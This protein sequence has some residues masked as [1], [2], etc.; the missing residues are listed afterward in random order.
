MFRVRRI[1]KPNNRADT[2][3]LAGLLKRICAAYEAKGR[4]PAT[5]YMSGFATP[6]DEITVCAEWDQESIESNPRAKV[7][8]IIINKYAGE[9]SALARSNEVEFHE[10]ATDEK[11]RQWGE[12]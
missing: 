10:I 5:I 11:L 4:N 3:K 1:C 7:P 12:S 2:W 8:E 6:G 9:L